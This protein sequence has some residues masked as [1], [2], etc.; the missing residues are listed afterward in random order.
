MKVNEYIPVTKYSPFQQLYPQMQLVRKFQDF[1]GPSNSEIQ[2]LSRTNPVFKHFQGLEYWGKNQGLLRICVGILYTN[3][4]NYI[5]PLSSLLFVVYFVH[6]HIKQTCILQPLLHS[7]F[8]ATT[9]R[10]VSLRLTISKHR[11]VEVRETP[12]L[13]S[14]TCLVLS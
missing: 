5:Q 6:K 4:S 12:C 14:S 13:G 3:S 7:A 1:Q 11:C 2:G 10:Q 8:V 9:V